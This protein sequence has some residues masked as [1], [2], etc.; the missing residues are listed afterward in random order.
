P[1][2]AGSSGPH[3]EEDTCFVCGTRTECALYIASTPCASPRVGHRQVSSSV[4]E[5]VEQRTRRITVLPKA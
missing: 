2:D 5:A 4:G 1:A 3:T